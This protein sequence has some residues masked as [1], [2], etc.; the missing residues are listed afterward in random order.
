MRFWGSRSGL[1]GEGW[2]NP[3]ISSGWPA[4]HPR[5][6]PNSPP[7]D[8]RWHGDNPMVLGMSAVASRGTFCRGLG[9]S[10]ALR[11]RGNLVGP[12]GNNKALE[13]VVLLLRPGADPG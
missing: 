12:L 9:S 8:T 2:R 5:W 1:G 3:V 10:L 7:T 6:A 11:G 13:A 4:R